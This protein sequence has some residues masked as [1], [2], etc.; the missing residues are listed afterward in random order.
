MVGTADVEVEVAVLLPKA[1]PFSALEVVEVEALDPTS[2]VLEDEDVLV[3]PV[4]VAF[5]VMVELSVN[6][7]PNRLESVWVLMEVSGAYVRLVPVG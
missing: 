6:S 7:V 5:E 4:P 3:D 2:S 1:V